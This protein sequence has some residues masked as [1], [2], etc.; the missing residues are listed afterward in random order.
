MQEENKESTDFFSSYNGLGRPALAWGVPVFIFITMF[1]LI[2]STFFIGIILGFGFFS[3][4]IPMILFTVIFFIKIKC[5]SNNRAIEIIKI[6]IYGF[7]LRLKSGGKILTLT[8]NKYSRKERIKNVRK[9][10]K[11]N[12]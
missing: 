7:L 11:K 4:L 2:I 12:N 8:S 9:F 5:E 1:F 10:I 6:N 3:I